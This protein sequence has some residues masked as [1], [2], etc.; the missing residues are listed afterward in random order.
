MEKE[1]KAKIKLTKTKHTNT[2]ELV[3]QAPQEK[4]LSKDHSD[5]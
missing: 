2:D 3:Q 5:V 1:K 4:P